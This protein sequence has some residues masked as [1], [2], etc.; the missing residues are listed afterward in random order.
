MKNY[1]VAV[2]MSIACVSCF[3]QS[4]STV[5]FSISKPSGDTSLIYTF[6]E[7]MPEYP[8]GDAELMKY[9]RSSMKYPQ[10]EKDNHISGKVVIRFVVEADGTVRNTMVVKSASPSIDKE[11]MRVLK[12][13]RFAPAVQQGKPVR[14]YYNLPIY[15]DFK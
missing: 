6:A 14:V 11:V 15:I 13:L 12:T 5:K 10:M 2:M 1:F 7:K 8:G 9:I 3:A 4:D